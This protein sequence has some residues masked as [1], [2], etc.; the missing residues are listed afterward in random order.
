MKKCA[1]ETTDS[2][3]ETWTGL[4]W[5]CGRFVNDS[6]SAHE[7][8]EERKWRKERMLI[9]RKRKRKGCKVTWGE[10]EKAVKRKRKRKK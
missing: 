6:L 8:K 3:L 9:Q 2:Q 4:Y 10:R 7:E 1:A 5:N